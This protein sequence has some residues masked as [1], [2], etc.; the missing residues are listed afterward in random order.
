MHAHTHLL[1][2]EAIPSA[3]VVSGTIHWHRAAPEHTARAKLLVLPS[4]LLL[5]SNRRNYYVESTHEYL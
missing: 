2:A 1:H 5:L 3:K 4:V